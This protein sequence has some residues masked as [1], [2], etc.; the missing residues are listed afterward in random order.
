[1]HN[2]GAQPEGQAKGGRGSALRGDMAG[3]SSRLVRGTAGQA[4]RADGQGEATQAGTDLG[5]Q[6]RVAAREHRLVV[7]SGKAQGTPPEGDS[8]AGS[9]EQV[10]GPVARVWGRPVPGEGRLEGEVENRSAGVA[11][12]AEAR[13]SCES[14]SR[15]GEVPVGSETP[16]WVEANK[17]LEVVARTRTSEAEGQAV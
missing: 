2:W 16:S 3:G 13:E 15:E 6:M 8:Q 10:L 7:A 4:G 11:K 17:A 9:V 14:K 12:E 1:M 5:A